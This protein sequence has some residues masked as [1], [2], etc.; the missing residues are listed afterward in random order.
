MGHDVS[1]LLEELDVLTKATSPW[2]SKLHFAFQDANNLY[3][4]M[5]CH[6]GDLRSMLTRYEGDLEEDIARFYVGETTLAIH[7]LHLMGYVHRDVKPEN[8]LLDCRGHVMLAGF[9]FAAKLDHTQKT[10]SRMAIRPPEY[11]SPYL[12][13]KLLETNQRQNV[14]YGTEVDWWSLGICLYEMMYG[15]LPFTDNAAYSILNY[16]KYL[17]FPEHDRKNSIAD[18]LIRKLLTIQDDGVKYSEI[19]KHSFLASFSWDKARK[20]P[21]APGLNSVGSKSD[22]CGS[23]MNHSRQTWDN[24]SGRLQGS[25]DCKPIEAT[26]QWCQQ[27]EKDNRSMSLVKCLDITTY[28][29]SQQQ[30]QTEKIYNYHESCN[31]EYKKIAGNHSNHQQHDSHTNEGFSVLRHTLL[32]QLEEAEKKCKFQNEMMDKTKIEKNDYECQIKTLEKSIEDLKIRLEESQV[33]QMQLQQAYTKLTDEFQKY[34]IEANVRSI[35]E[36]QTKSILTQ[37]VEELKSIIHAKDERVQHLEKEMTQAKHALSKTQSSFDQTK[38]KLEENEM[39]L[40]HVYC[41]LEVT[42]VNLETEIVQWQKRNKSLQ[43]KINCFTGDVEHQN[44]LLKEEEEKYNRLCLKHKE[45]EASCVELTTENEKLDMCLRQQKEENLILQ[46]RLDHLN[47][48][49]ISL[50]TVKDDLDQRLSQTSFKLE[51]QSTDLMNMSERLE[52]AERKCLNLI[53]TLDKVSKENTAYDSKIKTLERNVEDL[54]FRLEESKVTHTKQHLAYLC[55]YKSVMLALPLVND[56]SL[57]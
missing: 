40:K 45:S 3:L 5:E 54:N 26:K 32:K 53:K 7:N 6:C 48:D 23:D 57:A 11:I 8:V 44:K 31:E 1:Y 41:E 20:A 28:K 4:V 56:H 9:G 43:D 18:D 36:T 13:P 12:S 30:H 52:E 2:I 42:K 22:P 25:A 33:N 35:E 14:T 24:I 50:R 46:M 10:T 51:I 55:F 15:Q 39:T 49:L 29:V 34:T 38:A 16:K 17:K 19:E 37:Q 47:N 21:C 27:R